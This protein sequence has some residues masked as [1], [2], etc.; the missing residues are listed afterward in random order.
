[1]PCP[2]KQV[3]FQPI[4]NCCYNSYRIQAIASPLV[5][6]EPQWYKTVAV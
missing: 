2:Y 4:A 6:D 5:T 3:E 1:M